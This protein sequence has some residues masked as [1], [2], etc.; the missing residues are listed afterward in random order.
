MHHL[1][2]RTL[3]VVALAVLTVVAGAC[4]EDEPPVSLNDND[5]GVECESEE[6]C[7]DDQQCDMDANE[8]VPDTDGAECEDD[9]DC[10]VTGQACEDGTC[11]YVEH[12][13]SSVGE[14]CERGEPTAEGFSCQDLGRGDRCY[15]KCA[16][17][18]TCDEDAG[19]PDPAGETY[20][21]R[22][23]TCVDADDDENVEVSV[24]QPSECSD[25]FDTDEGCA[26]LREQ[27]SEELKDGE[28][29]VEIGVETYVCKGAGTAGEGE[30]CE[31]TTDCAEGLTCVD[32]MPQAADDMPMPE[33][34]GPDGFCAR[35]CD[36]DEMCGAD[37]GCIG[38]DDG[39]YD[40][41]GF[42]GDHCDP[43]GHTGDQCGDDK[44]CVPVSGEDG[45]CYRDTTNERDYY[46]E[47]ESTEQCP[48]SSQ[49][50]GLFEGQPSQCM[51]LC[52][53]TL[54]SD[55][56]Q[57]ATC[58]SADGEDRQLSGDCVDLAMQLQGYEGPTE[59]GTGVCFEACRDSD[60]WGKGACS[61]EN[62]ACDPVGEDV[63]WCFPAGE[64]EQGDNCEADDECGD[65]LH[66]DL[67]GEGGGTC[68]SLCQTGA[69]TNDNLGC[70]SHETCIGM[71]GYDNL[72]ECRLPC[73]PGPDGTDP[74]CPEGQQT[75]LGSG[76]DA[77]CL[78]S[79]DLAHGEACGSP[80]EQNCAPGMVCAGS[81]TDLTG[82]LT[83]P[84]SDAD[85]PSEATCRRICEPFVGDFGDSGCPD[86]YACS[87]VTPEGESRTDGHCVPAMDDVIG[88]LEDCP[89]D[90]AGMMCDENSFCIESTGGN[91]CTEDTYQCVQFCD[92]TTG[93]GCTGD[94]SCSEGFQGGALFGWLGLC[95]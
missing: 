41:V 25:F 24:C 50:L 5:D 64:G 79:G 36:G 44:A 54:A 69:Q 38:D 1:A 78:A 95:T 20:C 7:D 19:F 73:E 18:R 86:G 80:E 21:N 66:C 28:H 40:G 87:P 43:F 37:E 62:Q 9:D 83:E 8:C 60:D 90:Q 89:A 52:D 88:G 26:D 34:L 16:E 57:S 48:D 45:V 2:G 65:G 47:C 61:A 71:D 13:C 10:L 58:P 22:G 76:D 35:A 4:G 3:A 59:I 53:P 23:E 67:G 77:Y 92:Y 51:P 74:N 82:V 91:E 68:R 14:E 42:C 46:E 93:A 81:R 63:G 27:D 94:T 12:Q 84:F 70:E 32:E 49:C 85:G 72:G 39:V 31:E 11:E 56:E 6:D 29:C 30:H 55:D 17:V 15:E 75:C 33:S